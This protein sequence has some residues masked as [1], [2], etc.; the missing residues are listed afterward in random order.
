MRSRLCGSRFFYGDFAIGS[1]IPS[2]LHFAIGGQF[3]NCVH[4]TENLS[5]FDDSVQKSDYFT[6]QKKEF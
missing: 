6:R 1:P 3:A 2:D 5:I 4:F